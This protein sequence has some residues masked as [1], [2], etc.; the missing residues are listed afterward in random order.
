MRAARCEVAA[1]RQFSALAHAVP[2]SEAL[3]WSSQISAPEVTKPLVPSYPVRGP[4]PR[5]PAGRF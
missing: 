4:G 5:V 3:A 2:V 1:F